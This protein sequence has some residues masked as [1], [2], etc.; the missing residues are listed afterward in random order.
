[1]SY[2]SFSF[3]NLTANKTSFGPDESVTIS[4]RVT[5]TGSKSGKEVVQLFISDVIAFT[6]TPDVKRLRAFDKIMLGAGESKTVEFK[7][8][9][10]VLAF[11]APD[12][13]KHLEQG[14]FKL[15]IGNL[16]TTFTVTKST[17]F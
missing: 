5:N 1:M 8:P 17:I 12:N 9:V 4:V 2:T 14:N 7:I 11:V 3:S 16:N 10:K 15:M 6:I 13:K